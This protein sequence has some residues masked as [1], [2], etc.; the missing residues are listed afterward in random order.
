MTA[1]STLFEAHDIHARIFDFYDTHRRHLPWRTHNPDPYKVWLSEILLQQTTVKGAAPYFQKFIARWPHVNALATASLEEVMGAFAGLGYYSRA[2][3][4]HACARKISAQGGLFPQEE[5][6]LRELPGIGAYTAA[7]IAAIAFE[8]P[9]LPIDGN[10]ARILSRL[11]GFVTPVALNR[12]ALEALAQ[13]LVPPQRRGDFAQAL[14]DIGATLCRPRAPDCP[15]CPLQDRCHAYAT[16]QPEAFPQKPVKTQRPQ[17]IGAVFFAYRADGTFLARRRPLRGLLG[18]TMELPSGHWI[19]KK[20][21]LSDIDL[22]QAPFSAEWTRLPGEVSHIFTHFSL[23]LQVFA[24]HA[25]P[26]PPKGLIF[27]TPQEIEV[28]G[29]STLMRKVLT[30]AQKTLCLTSATEPHEF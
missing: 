14:M 10:I 4:L 16:G 1:S 15:S 9:C 23:C 6:S 29:F 30:L 24:A 28:I 13:T 26:M 8:K 19:E 7:A 18:G 25:P 21:N 2:R 27:V 5:Q 3:N 22:N 17:K 11:A 12:P 20:P